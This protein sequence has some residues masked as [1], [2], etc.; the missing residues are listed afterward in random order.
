MQTKS[1]T[2][3]QPVIT[4]LPAPTRLRPSATMARFSVAALVAAL[5]VLAVSLVAAQPAGGGF[6]N[7]RPP[8]AR[9]GAALDAHAAPL[10]S[11]HTAHACSA[12]AS[13]ARAMRRRASNP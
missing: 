12:A 10:R 2:K 5:V 9:C 8:A 3:K 4:L 11:L 6:R 13:P 7:V 1:Q